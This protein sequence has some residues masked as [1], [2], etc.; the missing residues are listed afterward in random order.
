MGIF[1]KII[2][3]ITI[4]AGILLVVSILGA[5]GGIQVIIS[6]VVLFSLGSIYDNVREIKERLEG[7][8]DDKGD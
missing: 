8:R 5:L 1:L 4:I 3:I 6:G 7:R 2:G